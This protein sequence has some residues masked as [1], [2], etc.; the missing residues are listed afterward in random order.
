MPFDSNHSDKRDQPSV[1]DALVFRFKATL[2]Q[3]NR[4]ARNLLKREAARFPVGDALSAQTV[5]SES[6]TPL[7]SS[8]EKSEKS[9]QAGKV[10]NLRVAVRRLNGVLV[11]AG[12]VFSF[13]A[14]V[15]RASVWKG[16][17]R[18]RELREGCLIPST[19]GG[20]CQLSNALYDAALRAGFE[21]VE[22]HAHTQIIPG[23]LGEVGRDATIFWNYV[24]LRFK[25]RHPF[26]IEAMLDK[27]FLTVRFRS[28]A[29]PSQHPSQTSTKKSF[30]ALSQHAPQSCASCG[31]HECFRHVEDKSDAIDFGRTAYLV[32]E[33]YPE[34]DN[35]IQETRGARDLLALPI[36]GSKIGKANYAWSTRG[37]GEVRQKFLITL[38]RAY[39]SRKLTLQGAARQRALLAFS[40]KLATSYAGL[41]A[42]DITHV[43]VTQN[44]LPFLWRDGHLGG[45]TF[46]VLMTALPLTHLHERLNL[47]HR[48]HPESKT[49]ADFRA[50]DWLVKAENEALRHA[51]KVITPHTEIAAIHQDRAVLAE[52]VRPQGKP[53]INRGANDRAKIVFP[54][55]TV[56]RKGAY[57][58]RA[59]V[60]GLNL[61]LVTTGS[62]LEGK[63]FWRGVCVEHKAYQP[64]WLDGAAAVILP[65]FVEHKPRRLL[66]AVA[67]GV[68]VIAST[69]CGLENVKGV[70][71]V[72]VGDVDALRSEIKGVVQC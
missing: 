30:I 71:N 63:D 55:A 22:R 61:R 72:A 67:R 2:L 15:G 62:Q 70:V 37:F 13:W 48:L 42:Y 5:I 51:R 39:K 8:N 9:L 18:G 19:G 45:R 7:W 53:S 29:R 35:Y 3:A 60:Q 10:H 57:E 68:P 33:Y 34:F 32:D 46:D 69:A 23:S 4:A 12:G 54:S 26:R 65:A 64:D 40:E 36:D 14:Q 50:Q 20:L 38:L 43:C 41:L 27:D 58:M 24:D 66:E 16:Y 21:I 44:L 52:W 47:A 59:A 28:G 11:P 56:G 17:V 49:L 1:G 6:K 31:V 25:S